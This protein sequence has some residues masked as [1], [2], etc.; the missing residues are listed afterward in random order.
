MSLTELESDGTKLLEVDENTI[1]LPLADCAGEPLPPF[2]V[3]PPGA[4]ENLDIPPIVRKGFTLWAMAIDKDA[5]PTKK[6]RHLML[7]SFMR[8]NILMDAIL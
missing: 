5:T 6:S 3:A 1:N 7:R 2:G 4:A 8:R